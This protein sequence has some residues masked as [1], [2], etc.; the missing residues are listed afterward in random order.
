M[1]KLDVQFCPLCG[2]HVKELPIIDGTLHPTCP[3]CGWRYFPDPKTAVAIFI[4]K[5]DSVLLIRRGIEPMKGSWALPAG[6]MN[7]YEDPA[8][9][10][11]REALEETGLVVRVKRLVDAV[12]GRE[13]ENGADV[14]LIYQAEITGGELKACDDAE[15][16]AFFKRDELPPLAFRA[17]RIALGLESNPY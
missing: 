1:K 10:A 16:A 6:Y 13:S 3:H 9:A 2:R 11:E 8:R 7:A 15:A 5:D 12:G 14:V 4:E 17:S